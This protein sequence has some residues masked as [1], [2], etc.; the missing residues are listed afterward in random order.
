MASIKKQINGFTV[1]EVI[2][3]IVAVII[4]VGIVILMQQK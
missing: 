2:V 4:L 3:V 1:L